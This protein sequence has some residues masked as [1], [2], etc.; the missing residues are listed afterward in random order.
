[1]AAPLPWLKPAVLVGGLAPLGL[2]LQGW[3]QDTLGANPVEAA[4]HQLGLL[5]LVFLLASLVPS[6]LK[7]LTGWTWPQRL[8]RMLGLFAFAYASLHLLVY[9]VLDQ[10]FAWGTLLEDVTKRRFIAVGFAAWVV[11][12]PLAL[13]S[14]NASVRRLGFPRWQRLHRLAYLAAV[15]GVVHFVWRVKK[16]LTE[17]LVYAGVLALLLAL[18]LPQWLKQWRAARARSA[19]ASVS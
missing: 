11:L 12:L 5:A 6:A 18:R 14:T 19:R 9:V 13:T 15:A 16:D 4:L 3:Q 8:R 2:L 17:P 1:M 7:Q 10:R